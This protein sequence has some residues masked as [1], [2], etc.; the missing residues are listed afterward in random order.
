MWSGK[1]QDEA[2]SAA[3]K[4]V[5]PV[6]PETPVFAE[7]DAKPKM[8]RLGNPGKDS[9]D[10]VAVT[11]NN[12]TACVERVELNVNEYKESVK[13]S[14]PLVLMEAPK[15]KLPVAKPYSTIGIHVWVG[16]EEKEIPMVTKGG[17][18]AEEF[19]KL[20]AKSQAEIS[21]QNATSLLESQYVWKMEKVSS[22]EANL[23]LTIVRDGLPIV[24]IKKIFRVDPKSYD[25]YLSHEVQ[26]LTNQ[27]VRVAIDQLASTDL[28]L[29]PTQSDDRFLP[30][31]GAGTRRS[32]W[33]VADRFNLL[34]GALDKSETKEI[35][36]FEGE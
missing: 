22:Y 1:P 33:S 27:A 32:G 26:N 24:R 29:D 34:H 5:Y 7:E 3:M 15:T 21:A 30:C 13:G 16:Q 36:K 31:R 20:K 4:P 23:Y 12:V 19:A 17:M 9:K 6:L 28:P 14:D 8:E 10:W 25:V 18:T 2:N 11:I 35:G